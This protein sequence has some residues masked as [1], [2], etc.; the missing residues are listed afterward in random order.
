MTDASDMILESIRDPGLPTYTFFYTINNRIV[1][2]YFNSSSEAL[3]WL[4]DNV[5]NQTSTNNS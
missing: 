5:S 1:S 3:E 4:S 2:P